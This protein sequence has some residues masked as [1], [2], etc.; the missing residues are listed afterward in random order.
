MTPDQL[1]KL[2]QLL[3]DGRPWVPFPGPQIMAAQ[4]LADEVFF[5]GAAGGGKS[6][7]LVGLAGTEHRNSIIYRREFPQ[8]REIIEQ[9]RRLFSGR[10]GYNSQQH[11]WRL[12]NGRVVEFGAVQRE[13]D[14]EKYQGRPHDFIGFDELPQ[15]SRTQ[16]RF[17]IGWNRTT[18][19][20][21]RCRVV[22]AG[23]PPTTAEGRWVIEEWAPWL[24][25]KHHNP[26]LPGE[27]RWYT[28]VDGVLTWVPDGQPFQHKGELLQPRSR[29]FIPARLKDNPVLETTGYGSVLQAMP[30]PLRSQML[31]GDFRAGLEDDA[32]QVIPTAW[33]EAAM[34]RWTPDSHGNKPLTS[35]GADIAR[36]GS[37]KTVL[38]KRYGTWFSPLL[39]YPGKSTP[40][41][42]AVGAL[43]A[44]AVKENTEA[45]ANLDMIGVGAAVMDECQRRGIRYVGTNFAAT[46]TKRDIYGVI[47]FVNIRAFAYWYL[48]DMFDP[49]QKQNLQLPKDPELLA[50]L[51]APRYKAVPGG[52][53]LES[54]EDLVKRLGRSPD[55]G[56]AV[57]YAAM[58]V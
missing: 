37:A 32:W 44:D 14:A 45:V 12:N 52:I 8:L 34:K 10:G 2:D 50:D 26:A 27:V 54:K 20:H 35:V 29:T 36:G 46:A 15:F 11:L 16:Y 7:L 22:G 3:A 58:P 57:V 30:E 43:I 13:W 17:L 19:P 38:A 4:S 40:D 51:T 23:N 25:D 21:Q 41:G 31:Y 42:P 24:D 6:A 18:D 9:S 28:V 55:C 39:K 47:D 49:K 1:K 56:D 48:R 53:Q 5:G 33:V